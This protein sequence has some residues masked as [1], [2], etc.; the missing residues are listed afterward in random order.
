MA[1]KLTLGL[2]IS[3]RTPLRRARSE[4]RMDYAHRFDETGNPRRPIAD[5]MTARHMLRRGFSEDD[6][7]H[8][9]GHLPDPETLVDEPALGQP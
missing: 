8:V 7:R 5:A 4:P 6:V 3:E 9:L 2:M 1:E